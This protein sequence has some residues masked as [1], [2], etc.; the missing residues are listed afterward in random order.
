MAPRLANKNALVNGG[1]RGKRTPGVDV[2]LA[3][4]LSHARY[5]EG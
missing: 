4:G 1:A 5:G 2:V 3:A